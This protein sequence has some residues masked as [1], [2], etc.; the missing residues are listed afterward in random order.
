MEKGCEK[1]AIQGDQKIFA[2]RTHFSKERNV[3]E[4]RSRLLSFWLS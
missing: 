4:H 2:R 1:D 3:I